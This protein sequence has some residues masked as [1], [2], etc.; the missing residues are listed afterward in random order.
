MKPYGPLRGRDAALATAQ[1]VVRRAGVVLITGEPGIGKTAALSEIAAR[2]AHL[3]VRVARGK[4][5]EI[6]Q[7]WPGAPILGLLRA[8]R[9]PLVAASEFEDLAG[10][11]GS[12]LLLVE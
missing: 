12:P 1:Q 3:R 6:G 5:D 10:L 7:A 9:D 11:T 8:G 2:A 4:C